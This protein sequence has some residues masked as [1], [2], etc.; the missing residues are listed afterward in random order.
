MLNWDDIETVLLDMDGTLLDLH[1][2]NHF[3][4]VHVPARFAT[5]NNLTLEEAQ[6]LLFTLFD[7]QKGS[8]NWYCLD[9]WSDTLKLD[10]PALKQEVSDLIR[11]RP[12]VIPF[13]SWLSE[14][15]H[16][17]YL[18]TNAHQKSLA[19]KLEKTGIAP[20]F[21][22]LY[23]S[24]DFDAPKESQAFWRRFQKHTHF[25]N[26]STVLIDD[27][28]SVLKSAQLFGIQHL[29]SIEQPDS[30]VSPREPGEFPAVSCYSQLL[31]N[32]S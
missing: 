27:S 23:C 25:D 22:K 24:H 16:T 32:P 28:E 13:L 18:V 17:V 1:F 26:S 6:S 15:K 12:K 20:Y 29:L 19:L 21:D 2:D 11:I 3:W 4:L 8:L 7:K 9:Y 30:K 10:I 14:S 31:P 5:E